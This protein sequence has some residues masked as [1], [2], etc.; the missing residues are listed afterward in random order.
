METAQ[1]SVCMLRKPSFGDVTGC[2]CTLR[3]VATC[4]SC[5]SPSAV[6]RPT[7]T[8]LYFELTVHKQERQVLHKKGVATISLSLSLLVI[9]REIYLHVSV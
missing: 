3:W 7:A 1:T 6:N 9:L 8:Q 2:T 5:R 4:K